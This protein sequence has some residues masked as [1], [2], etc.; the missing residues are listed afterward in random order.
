M[1][2]AAPEQPL[3]AI[4]AALLMPP[5]LACPHA[6]APFLRRAPVPV[7]VRACLEWM[8]AHAELNALFDD[9]A[10]DQ[11]TRS[12][13]LDF[14]ADLLLD[15]ACGTQPSAHAALKARREQIDIS[16]QAFY[17]KL[18][19]M[20]LPVSEAVAARFADLAETVM[21]HCGF[22]GSEPIPG[23]AARVLDGTV[24]GGR[25]EHRIAPLRGVR[26]AG[27]TGHALAVYAPARRTVRQLVLD[28]DA[29]TQERAMLPRVQVQA[30]EVWIAD[31]NFC[32]LSFLFRLQRQGAVFTIRWH[33][34]NCPFEEL[35]PPASA[36]G[37][38]Q[39]ALEQP[40]RLTDPDAGQIMTVRRIVLPLERHS[41]SGDTELIL[42]TNLPQTIGADVICDAYRD[43]WKIETHFQR[44]T[45]Q[46]HCEPPALDMPRAAL[47][48]F[49]MSNV[50]G[51]ALALVLAVL[52][53]AHGEE[54]VRELSY[55]FF[56][57]EISQIWL[58]MEV[59][60][61]PEEWSFVRAAT[62]ETLADWLLA[63]ARHA[64][65]AYFRRSKRGPKKPPTKKK[66]AD[67]RTHV[68][69]KRMIDEALHRPA[70]YQNS[71]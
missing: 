55:Y 60:V 14:L 48:A 28:E 52:Q 1:R 27:L 3:R 58:G 32:V 51:N 8:T 38:T 12:L 65:M 21:A 20:E 10:Q 5:A 70:N 56:V 36:P 29:Y 9:T 44:L 31:R 37:S 42:V 50:A 13:T 66:A 7:L 71:H 62:A 6:L 57:L 16:R 69:N 45:Q 30:G 49:A 19:R 2:A 59:A 67:R 33:A 47:F 18:A 39:G 61:P 68:S 34:Q 17:A 15:V 64:D 43:R 4:D 11:Y 46:L 53:A 63:L 41:R 40:V 54:A 23:F 26:A 22:T 25:T 24:L 35:T